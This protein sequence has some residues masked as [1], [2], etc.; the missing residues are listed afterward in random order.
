[1][2]S[3]IEKD[4]EPI[5]ISDLLEE[6]QEDEMAIT[7]DDIVFELIQS[8]EDNSYKICAYHLEKPEIS[9]ITK[10]SLKNKKKVIEY[11]QFNQIFKKAN[12]IK[13]LSKLKD[14]ELE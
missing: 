12:N 6:I 8:T 1:M 14:W 4:F 7:E 2:K 11:L 10:N 5:N 13:A 3:F 9:V